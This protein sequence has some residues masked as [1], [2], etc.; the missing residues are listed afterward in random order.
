MNFEAEE[1]PAWRARGAPVRDAALIASVDACLE[2]IEPGRRVAGRPGRWDADVLNAT[3][4]AAMVEVRALKPL[5]VEILLELVDLRGAVALAVAGEAAAQV[6][7][8]QRALARLRGAASAEQLLRRAP[9]AIAECLDFDRVIISRVKD[10]QWV[11]VAVHVE[12]HPRWAAHILAM[13]TAQQQPLDQMV[14]ETEMVRRRRPL[15]VRDVQERPDMHQAIAASSDSHSYVAAPIMPEGQVIG[16]IH[17]DLRLSGR[18]P[19]EHHRDVLFAFA[20]AFG[21]MVERA[22]LLDRLRDLEDQAAAFASG[23]Q[24]AFERLR[25]DAVSLIEDGSAGEG[26]RPLRAPAPPSDHRRLEQLT[27]RE[28]EVT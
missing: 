15:L 7:G 5:P 3:L 24:G 22:A 19:N 9:E 25:G 4:E 28:L 27:G 8:L 11:P 16:F 26:E 10:R 1:V 2:R 18:H 21:L 13:A 17:G 20:E 14:L 12:G 23:L 6:G